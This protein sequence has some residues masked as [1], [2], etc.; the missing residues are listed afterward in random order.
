MTTNALK[1]GK[2]R[3]YNARCVCIVE[4]SKR[5]MKPS[6]AL[7]EHRDA[8]LRMAREVGAGNVRIFGSVLYGE[9]Q[10]GSDLDPLVDVPRGTTL[11]DMARLQAALEDEL[12]VSVD[13]LTAEDLPPSF[14]HQ[15]LEE[16]MPL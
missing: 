2:H 11:L 3:P 16:A 14:R 10:E 9:D 4:G 1:F 7:D 5:N 12:G 8:V 6:Q 15:L 13:V